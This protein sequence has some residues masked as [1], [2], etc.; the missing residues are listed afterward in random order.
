MGP[1]LVL[2]AIVDT[3]CVTALHQV[4]GMLLCCLCMFVQL[5]DPFPEVR[6]CLEDWMDV[7]YD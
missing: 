3:F 5:Q 6:S 1:S 7:R 2:V 4:F